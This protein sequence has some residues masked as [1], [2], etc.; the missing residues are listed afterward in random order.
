MRVGVVGLTMGMYLA[1]WCRRLGME[2]AAACD[3]DPTRRAE[4]AELLPQA[5][6]FEDWSALLHHDLDAVVLA[7]NFDEH[8]PLAIAFLERGIHVLSESA[9]CVDEWQAAALLD[10]ERRSSATY[11]FAEN[12]VFHPHVQLI[13]NVLEAKEIGQVTLVEADYLHGMSPDDVSSLIGDP[14][15]W[16]GRI[17]PTA[18]CTHTLSPILALTGELP[19][20]VTAF[21]VDSADARAAVVMVVRLSG[22]GLAITRHGFLQGEPDSH[23]SWVSVRG[24]EDLAESVRAPGGVRGRCAC[25]RKAGPIGMASPAT[26]NA[27]PRRWP[28]P[29]AHSS[30]RKPKARSGSCKASGRAWRRVRHRSYRSARR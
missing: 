14:G 30:N 27:G 4:A 18:Y 21:H 19:T 28:S 26:R 10:A 12:Y 7:N 3:R 29:T 22:G 2:V 8:A 13:R 23:W 6:V 16:R 17:E 5:A 25:A 20:E 15:H 11:S 24:T 1:T 9:A